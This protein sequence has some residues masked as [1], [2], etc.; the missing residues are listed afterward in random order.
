MKKFTSKLT[1]G[2]LT[3]AVAGLGLA[4]TPQAAS[5]EIVFTVDDN[6]V[7]GTALLCVVPADCIFEADKITGL[8]NEVLTINPDFTFDASARAF[9]DSYD[10]G[11]ITA[12]TTGAVGCTDKNTVVTEHCYDMYALFKA[13]GSVD[14][15]TGDI[16]F[17]SGTVSVSLDPEDDNTYT[18]PA[19]GAGS[20]T[21]SAGAGNDISVISSGTLLAGTGNLKPP[22]GGFFDLTFGSFVFANP[23]AALYWPGLERFGLRATVDGDFNA[24]PS[25]PVPGT[26]S[27]VKGELSAVFV[28]EPTSL[29]L[30][31]LGFLGSAVAAR[32]RRQN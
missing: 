24:I 21:V 23:F 5:A 11:G 2:L 29:V 6:V 32:R 15:V 20:W 19:T 25:P 3:L 1:S 17:S 7:P 16:S 8:Y 27:D 9:L 28:P 31:G 4:L 18:A 12:G 30:L 22:V 10:L 13:S 14:P 26:Y